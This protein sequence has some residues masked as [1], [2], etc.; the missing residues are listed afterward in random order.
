MQ[1]LHKGIILMVASAAL[2]CVGQ[3]LWKLSA[4][5][6]NLVLI[7]MGLVLYGVGAVIMVKALGYGPLSVL[8]PIMS[9]GYILSLFLGALVLNE[10]VSFIRIFGVCAIIIG[11][12]FITRPEREEKQ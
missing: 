7:F 5:D 11:L 2:S 10:D 4:A 3:L 9:T 1:N 12:V 8:H 6:N